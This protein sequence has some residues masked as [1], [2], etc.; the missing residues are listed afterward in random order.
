MW[1]HELPTTL[2]TVLSQLKAKCQVQVWRLT[3]QSWCRSMS[4]EKYGQ[5]VEWQDRA[6]KCKDDV[7][8][9]FFRFVHLCLHV[10][11]SSCFT[12]SC[13]TN[14]LITPFQLVAAVSQFPLNCICNSV[15]SSAGI[16]MFIMEFFVLLP[17]STKQFLICAKFNQHE[18]TSRACCILWGCKCQAEPYLC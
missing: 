18:Q 16:E 2:M 3:K 13:D 17:S 10:W 8:Q 11:V 9:Y 14:N 6:L 15:H 1:A 7:V 5:N 12:V 4:L